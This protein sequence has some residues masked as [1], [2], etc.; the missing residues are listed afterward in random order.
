MNSSYRVLGLGIG[1]SVLLAACIAWLRPFGMTI[2]FLPDTGASWYYWQLPE[3]NRWAQLTAWLGYLG[4]QVFMWG[5]IAYGQ[6]QRLK[7]Q[8][9]L[10]RLNLIA[11]GGNLLFIVLHWAQTHWYYDALAQDVSVFSSQGSVILLLVMVLV[12]EAPRR[13]LLAGQKIAWMAQCRDLLK[14]YHGY[15]FCWATIYTFWYHPMESTPGH[16]VGFF[17]TFLLLLQGSLIFTRAHSN[18]YWTALLESFVLIHGSLVAWVNGGQMWPMFLFG[19]AGMFVITTMHGLGW[20]PWLRWSVLAAY[21]GGMALVYS[22]RGW[23]QLHEVLRIP[24]ILYLLAFLLAGLIWLGLY[25]RRRWVGTP[26]QR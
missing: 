7:P 19:F 9:G 8:A 18:R 24:L 23:S 15:L 13:G 1:V 22:E 11:L 4:H 17:Y 25:A 3:S 20:R 5:V 16:L 6:S 26:A 14:R 12:M 10:H 21:L 2:E